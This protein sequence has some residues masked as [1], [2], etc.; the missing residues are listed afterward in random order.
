MTNVPDM[1][2]AFLTRSFSLYLL[3]NQIKVIKIVKRTPMVLYIYIEIEGVLIYIE[4]EYSISLPRSKDSEVKL[5]LFSGYGHMGFQI[6]VFTRKL[7]LC[8]SW[9]RATTT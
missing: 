5:E 2:E 4:M 8:S 1:F 9:A 6:L 7:L 3:K